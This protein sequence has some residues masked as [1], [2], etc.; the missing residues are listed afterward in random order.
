MPPPKSPLFDPATALRAA[1]AFA[2]PPVKPSSLSPPKQRRPR[3]AASP[4]PAKARPL[5]SAPVSPEFLR[6]SLRGESFTAAPAPMLELPDSPSPTDFAEAATLGT[7]ASALPSPS[8]Q[9]TSL[10][11]SLT[12]SDD[13]AQFFLEHGDRAPVK[14]VHCVR[15][16]HPKRLVFTPYSLLVVPPDAARKGSGLSEHFVMSKD[17]VTH[18][19]DGEI[20]T[21]TP[22]EDWVNHAAIYGSVMRMPWFRY[23]L[24]R[25]TFHAWCVREPPCSALLR[26]APLTTPPRP[27]QK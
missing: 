8:K 17:G 27:G 20:S 25:K 12:T 2:L 21:F 24:E 16:E 4:S 9:F 3:P 23:F 18:M 6:H 14:F 1:D 10:Y 22:F 11:N 15:K 13:V 7:L 26:P 19:R 5:P